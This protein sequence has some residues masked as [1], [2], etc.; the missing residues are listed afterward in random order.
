MIGV[1]RRPPGLILACRGIFGLDQ[2]NSSL[3]RKN[4][5]ELWYNC[6]FSKV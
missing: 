3:G 4:M 2:T 5:A 1:I 6:H